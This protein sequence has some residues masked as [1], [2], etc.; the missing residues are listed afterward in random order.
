M[1]AGRRSLGTWI[2]S[3]ALGV[4]FLA[5]SSSS[6]GGADASSDAPSGT[7]GSSSDG[8][9]QTLGTCHWPDSLNDAGP[10]AC[11]VGRAYLNCTFPSGAGCGAVVSPG[12]L[13][14]SCISSDVTGCP[15]CDPAPGATCKDQCGPD[16]YAV[17]CG[18]PPHFP[19]DGSFT[20]QQAPTGCRDVGST[21]GGNTY[22][23]CPCD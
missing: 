14:E 21:P 2:G 23:C 9:P 4:A 1:D 6:G 5:C 10:G 3:A 12:P 7:S 18:G 11:T 16:E 20:Y 13:T 22:S 19:D 15:G 8:A 17:S